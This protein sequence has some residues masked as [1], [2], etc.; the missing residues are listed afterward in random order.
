M[1]SVQNRPDVESFNEPYPTDGT[2]RFHLVGF[3]RCLH[4]SGLR[5]NAYFAML[6]ILIWVNASSP[7]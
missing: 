3:A 2:P 7:S 6:M 1:L 5:K 4:G